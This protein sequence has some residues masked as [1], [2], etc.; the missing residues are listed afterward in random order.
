MRN[1]L[2]VTLSLVGLGLGLLTCVLQCFNHARAGDLAR[3]QREWEMR[4]AANGARQAF[5]AAHVAGLSSTSD[6]VS[7]RRAEQTQS[8]APQST[9]EVA[10]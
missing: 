4:A 7:R 3:L 2:L 8:E 6:L 5:L 10:P 9:P 1:L